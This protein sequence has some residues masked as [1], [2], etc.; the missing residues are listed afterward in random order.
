L[1]QAPRRNRYRPEND[2]MR[3]STE[4]TFRGISLE[5]FEKLYFDEEFNT[6]MCK[7]VKLARTVVKHEDDGKKLY[8]E[9]RIGPDRELP[10]PMKKVLK[11]DRLEYTEKMNYTWGSMDARW[12]TIP[13]VL[14]KKVEARGSIKFKEVSDGVLRIADGEIKVKVLGVGGM[15]EKLVINDVEQSFKNAARFTQD[16][17]DGKHS[18]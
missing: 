7:T 5:D 9:L 17:I 15:I 6:K 11:T 14:A 13:S 1:W 3:F 18:A 12:E 2:K 4:T 16:W 10:A 8:R